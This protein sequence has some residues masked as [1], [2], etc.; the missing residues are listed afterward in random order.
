MDGRSPQ[1]LRNARAIGY[2]GHLLLG[3]LYFFLSTLITEAPDLN[4]LFMLFGFLT[5]VLLLVSY[6]FR[7]Q[8]RLEQWAIV[9]ALVIATER[10]P[11]QQVRYFSEMAVD[12]QHPGFVR[13]VFKLMDRFG[14]PSAIAYF[15][16]FSKLHKAPLA[17]E[18][19]R[20][21]AKGLLGEAERNFKEALLGNPESLRVLAGKYL[22][23]GR[24]SLAVQ[25]EGQEG[26]RDLVGGQNPALVERYDRQRQLL[27][28]W[29]DLWCQECWVRAERIGLDLPG[30]EAG[31]LVCCKQCKKDG[32]LV[33]GLKKVLGLLGPCG[34]RA[35]GP[36]VLALP[37]WDSET[38]TLVPAEIDAVLIGGLPQEEVEWALAAL[39]E[40]L[41][42]HH[43]IEKLPV[44]VENG[45]PGNLSQNAKR[46]AAGFLKE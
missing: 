38:R 41:Q 10:G 12:I 29:P 31:A 1:V 15:K 40:T 20:R 2:G 34:D 28:A 46:L 11:F 8:G 32:S 45:M 7:G 21:R 27:A 13:K 17:L 14:G 33:K 3:T 25:V 19:E 4:L 9:Q 22:Y 30:G 43:P 23:Y 16:K 44:L 42:N 37:L 35:F 24:L 5:A 6:W 26:L 18:K 36:T 39:I